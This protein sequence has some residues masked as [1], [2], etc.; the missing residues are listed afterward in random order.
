[1]ARTKAKGRRGVKK[2]KDEAESGAAGPSSAPDA[3]SLIGMS[4]RLL[5]FHLLSI[6]SGTDGQRKR[7]SS[8][9]NRILSWLS[10]S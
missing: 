4:P 2:T 8:L 1:M 10:N 3:Q 5:F 6:R 9:D 7:T